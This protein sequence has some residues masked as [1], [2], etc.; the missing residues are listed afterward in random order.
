MRVVIDT[1][2]TASRYIS[3]QGAPAEVFGLWE[4]QVFELLVSEAILAEYERVLQYDKIRSRHRMSDDRIRQVIDDFREVA[5]L[6]T[7][8]ET[9]N[10]IPED[11]TDNRFLECAVAGGAQYIISGDRHLR[12][13]GDYRGIQILTPRALLTLVQEHHG[14]L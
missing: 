6:V 5:I 13:L 4:Q 12:D 1:N 11:P 2:V 7:P 14:Q 9:L 3:P 8:A 10:V